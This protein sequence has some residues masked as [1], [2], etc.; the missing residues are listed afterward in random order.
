MPIVCFRIFGSLKKFRKYALP[1]FP[2][3]GG[4]PSPLPC[5]MIILNPPP[6]FL[7]K[8]IPPMWYPDPVLQL[9][10]NSLSPNFPLKVKPPSRKGFLE[11]KPRKFENC[12]YYLYF[13][14]KITSER[15]GRNSTRMWFLTWRIKNFVWKVK[16][17]VRKYYITLLIDLAN[18]LYVVEKLLISFYAISY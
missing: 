3:V 11:K 16:Q 14:L 9:G 8:L 10:N 12:H 7:S 2:I 1:G 17:F 5:P 6:P 13:Y 15:D 18:K 4:T